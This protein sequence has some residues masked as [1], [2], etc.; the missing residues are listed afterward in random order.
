[1]IHLGAV[2][3]CIGLVAVIS[4]TVVVKTGEIF[5]EVFANRS[6]MVPEFDMH[7]L[8]GDDDEVMMLDEGFVDGIKEVVLNG[9]LGQ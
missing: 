3:F 6:L 1:M 8:G 7:L 5:D 4:Y 2:V 9:S